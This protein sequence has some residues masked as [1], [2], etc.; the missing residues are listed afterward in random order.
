[1]RRLKWRPVRVTLRRRTSRAARK[2]DDDAWEQ[3]IAR[4]PSLINAVCRRHRLA[5]YEAPDV[6][7]YVWM[8]LV[9]HINKLREPRALCG[10]ISATATHRCY[11]ILRTHKRSVIVDPLA[12][13]SFDLV[14]TAAK[15][16]DSEGLFSTDD[17]LLRA[18]QR[19]AVR[20]ALAELT[21]TQQQLLLLLVADPPVPYSEISRRMNLPVGSIGPTRARLVRKLQKSVAVRLL[22]EDLPIGVS[23]AA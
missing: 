20:Q 14:G 3:I 2:G 23:A 19:H 6:S 22:I 16:T 7:Q 9:R 11:E 13:G 5:S 12:I 10:W 8:Q 1:M 18:E 21:E 17:D 4:Y 15:S